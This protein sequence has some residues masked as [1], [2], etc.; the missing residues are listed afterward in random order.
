MKVSAVSGEVFRSDESKTFPGSY[1]APERDR[2]R[3]GDLLLARAS[4]SLRLVGR[5]ALV[6][7]TPGNLFL[8][9]KVLRLRMPAEVVDW[10][11]WFMRSPVGRSQIE[12][13]AS[14]IS[15]HN[16]TQGS[17][18]A[19]RL[20]MP[21]VDTRVVALATIEAAFVRADQL[22]AE[23]A[24]ARALL[25]RLEAAIL[26]KT[27]RGEL[28]PQDMNDEPASVLLDRIRADRAASPKPKR[29]RRPAAG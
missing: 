27:F 26:A 25:D 14:G 2:I 15:M 28:V 18:M 10:V 3:V 8:S 7:K 16:I 24:R 21:E 9:D 11:H 4:G 5:V 17:L 6:R 20:P 19:L 22:E 1:N 29:G 13:A 12:E 23:S